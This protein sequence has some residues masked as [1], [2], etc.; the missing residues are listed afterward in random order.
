MSERV[1]YIEIDLPVCSLTYGEGACLAAIGESNGA[2]GINANNSHK[3]FNTRSTCQ[4]LEGYDE[5]TQVL[6]LAVSTAALSRDIIAVPNIS[7]IRYTPP[8]IM[9]GRGIGARSSVTIQCG[10]HPFPDTGPGGDK[11][12]SERGYHA[13]ERGSFWGKVKARYP[14]LRGRGL[15]WYTGTVNDTLETMEERS[16]VIDRI[17]GPDTSGAVRIIAKDPLSVLDNKRAKAPSLSPCSVAEASISDSATVFTLT[18][19]DPAFLAQYPASGKVALGGKEIVSYTRSGST[20][21]IVRG[22][23]NT[24]AV[25]HDG[26]SRVQLCL[27]YSAESPADILY[28]LFTVYGNVDPSFISLSNWE[29]EVDEFLGFAYSGLVAEPRNVVE[30]VNEVCESAGISI[31]WDD[32][33]DT[34]QLQTVRRATIAGNV[35]DENTVL[36]SSFSQ[37]EQPETR[38]SQAWVYFGQINPIE[39]D[40]PNN[41]SESVLNVSLQ[42]ETDYGT[43]SIRETYSRWIPRGGFASASNVANITLSRFSLPP[44]MF[45]FSI[46]RDSGAPVPRLGSGAIVKSFFTQ[47]PTGAA[48]DIECQITSLRATDATWDVTG[49][50]FTRSDVPLPTPIAGLFVRAISTNTS[51]VV[52]S[53]E[54]RRQFAI[55][56]ESGDTV[57]L[58]IRSGVIISSVSVGSPAIDTGVDFPDGVNVEILIFPGAIV[59]GRG[60]NGGN[61][62]TNFPSGTNDNLSAGNGRDGGPALR[63]NTAVSITNNGTI[64]GGGGGFGAAA[65]SAIT[66]N[67]VGTTTS[68][69]TAVGGSGGAGG[70]FGGAA[71]VSS[72]FRAREAKSGLNGGVTLSGG[73][74]EANATDSRLFVVD[75][76]SGSISGQSPALGL[77]VAGVQ[78]DTFGS[79]GSFRS[80]RGNGGAPGP[81]VVGNSFI[82]WIEEGTRLGPIT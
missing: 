62:F 64:G 39:T 69:A 17:E 29:A 21:T 51:N 72:S 57:R 20:M 74:V 48:E 42:S 24:E 49:E 36:Q 18:P 16:F 4:Y 43:P 58:E 67:L 82:T 73:R 41:F 15:R 61:A 19:D 78:G 54:L 9:I 22:Q 23:N 30:L 55:M 70:G 38:V 33:Q 11:Y 35:Y 77:G 81:A 75:S 50:E 66:S 60:G 5:E 40:D 52:I 28:E 59:A 3:C 37:K 71:S 34:V 1:S 56:P 31:W 32:I 27:E 47:D 53:D 25:S 8:E 12:V 68:A 45:Q 7:D 44:R 65:L 46:L 2:F 76:V 80:R 10:D 6:R 63:A 26:G 13:F 79:G 14:F